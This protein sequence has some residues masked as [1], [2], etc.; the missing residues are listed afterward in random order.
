M[1]PYKK[2]AS[3][4]QARAA[5]SGALGPQMKAEAREKAHATPGGIKHLPNHVR[6]AHKVASDSIR[7][8]SYKHK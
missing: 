6:H 5:F 3:K 4:A 7:G 2:F 8:K 1:P